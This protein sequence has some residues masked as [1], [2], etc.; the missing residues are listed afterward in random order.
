MQSMLCLYRIDAAGAT[1]SSRG[2]NV[3]VS[4]Q[5]PTSVP[6]AWYIIPYDYQRAFFAGIK[7]IMPVNSY[8]ALKYGFLIELYKYKFK[9]PITVSFRLTRKS[10]L[11]RT[12]CLCAVKING[13]EHGGSVFVSAVFYWNCVMRYWANSNILLVN[14]LSWR[15]CSGVLWYV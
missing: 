1:S 3:C 7:W 15:Y 4:L 13:T 10:I 2:S 6:V 8:S 9:L 11:N 5:G 12:L 14:V